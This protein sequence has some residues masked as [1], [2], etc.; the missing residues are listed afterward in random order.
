M[1]GKKNSVKLIIQ[2]CNSLDYVSFMHIPREW[3]RVVDWLAKWASEDGLA[4]NIIDHRMLRLDL[5]H[6]LVQLVD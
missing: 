5:S 1:G 2:F 3:N 6:L 4:W